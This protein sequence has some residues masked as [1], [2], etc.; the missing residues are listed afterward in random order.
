MA[1]VVHHGGSGTTAAGVRAGVPSI[2]VPVVGDQLLWAQRISALG[3]GPDPIPRPKLTAERL[4]E[5]I[6]RALA[7]PTIRDRSRHMAEKI[8]A[9]EGVANAVRI[10]DGFIKG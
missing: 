1:A 6:Q 10:I 4:A 2:I 7:D 8:R 9:E 5:A 3:L